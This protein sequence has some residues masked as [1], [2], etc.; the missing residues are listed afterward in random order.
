MDDK[1]VENSNEECS[2][3]HMGSSKP[4]WIVNS[5]QMAAAANC[6]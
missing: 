2:P 4:T 6:H 5:P 3:D 1:I